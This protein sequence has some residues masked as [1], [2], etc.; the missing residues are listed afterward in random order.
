L[1]VSPEADPFTSVGTAAVPRSS[2]RDVVSS[3]FAG[4]APR[5]AADTASF[6]N[7]VVPMRRDI[8][9]LMRITNVP[10]SLLIAV[11]FH[12]AAV[13]PVIIALMRVIIALMFLVIR[14]M[15]VVNALTTDI[16]GVMSVIIGIM[17][18]V[19]GMTW[20]TKKVI[21]LLDEEARDAL[22]AA[23]RLLQ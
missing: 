13:A 2:A 9:A 22:A 17:W 19:I 1:V 12:I 15:F 4:Q 11:S 20:L 8:R 23:L 10:M 16:T 7:H 5:F 3:Q 18:L 14:V 21:V 6:D